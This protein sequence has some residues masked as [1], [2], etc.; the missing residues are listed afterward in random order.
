MRRVASE[1]GL[2]VPRIALGWLLTRPFVTSIIVGA[3]SL[4]QLRDNMG[5]TDARLDAEHVASL[6]A[7]SALPPEYPGWMLERQNGD[8]RPKDLA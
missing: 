4:D 1:T 7:A 3:K 2:S 8:R 6:D 5:A